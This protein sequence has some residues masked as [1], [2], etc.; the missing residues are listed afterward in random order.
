MTPQ[1]SPIFGMAAV[2]VDPEHAAN[3]R[4]AVEQLRT[5]F[6]VPAGKVLSWKEA[7]KTHDRRLRAANVMGDLNGI[8]VLYVYADKALLRSASYAQDLT[9]FYNYVAGKMFK[10]ILWA[11]K[12]WEGGPAKVHVRFGHVRHHDHNTTKNYL[13]SPVFTGDKNVPTHLLAGLK[14]VSATDFVESQAADLY[15]GFLRA[16]VWPKPTEWGE[17][18]VY[19][20]FLRRVWHQVRKVGGCAVPLGYF[21]MP[22]HKAAI[23]NQAFP[24]GHCPK[25]DGQTGTSGGRST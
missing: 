3:L 18:Y 14:W 12:H 10:S 5:D 25:R 19:P 9:L 15:G 23:N 17:S 11:A 4:A 7:C 20:E 6:H 16:A 2:L 8:T 1:S 22:D 24:C 21:V 13:Q